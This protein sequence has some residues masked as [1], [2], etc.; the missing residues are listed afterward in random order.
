MTSGVL[1]RIVRESGMGDLLA[2][3][4]RRLALTD[5]QSLLL[6]VYHERA[7][8]Q[9]PARVLDQYQHNRFV[10]PA[11]VDLRARA[12]LDR[13]AL[14]AAAAFAALDL[15]PVCPLGTTSALA[16]VDQNT[17]VST[18]RNTEVV[19]DCTN[20]LALECA[21]RRRAHRQDQAG[22][23]A[24]VRLCTSQRLVRA[25]NY[26]QPGLNAHFSIFALC[27]AGRAVA[28]YRLEVEAL[29]EHLACYV[30]LLTA[31]RAIG[32]DLQDVR[33][34]F[35]DLPDPALRER[36]QNEVIPG[37]AA[38]FPATR[39]EC[40]PGRVTVPGYYQLVRFHIYARAAD[41]TEHE[42]ADGGFTDWT[43]RLLG[44]RKERLLISGIATERIC[45]LARR[46]VARPPR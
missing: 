45:T 23:A 31:A 9:T 12:H 36:L 37:V 18:I 28:D 44:D 32:Y 39:L 30:T 2:F 38:R 4:G 8:R 26:H 16:P 34:V 7:A 19:S 42:L 24:R 20:V 25:Q 43:Q 15:A 1:D 41:G 6:A 40:D 21:V 46:D 10:R 13:L 3:L 29:A 27:T 17:V 22:A 33:I 14:D 35:T 5:L 11:A